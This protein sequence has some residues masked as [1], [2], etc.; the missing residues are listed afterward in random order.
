MT[1]IANAETQQSPLDNG[2]DLSAL[3]V[4]MSAC[5]QQWPDVAIEVDEPLNPDGQWWIE[6]R[7]ANFIFTLIW[8]AGSGFGF[9]TDFEASA[10]WE[11]PAEIH[12]SPE[13]AIKRLGQLYEQRSNPDQLSGALLRHVRE[14]SG[15]TQVELSERIRRKQSAISRS[16]SQDVS[17]LTIKSFKEFAEGS[18]FSIEIKL[19]SEQSDITLPLSHLIQR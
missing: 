12:R 15:L 11:K 10:D 5:R 19:H 1:M 14:L 4:F 6:V 8:K 2:V 18:G 16:E 17:K 9:Y 3:E 7:L 13:Q